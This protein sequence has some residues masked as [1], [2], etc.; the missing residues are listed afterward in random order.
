[1]VVTFFLSN[2]KSVGTL[3]GKIADFDVRQSTMR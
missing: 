2:K 3:T 1:M